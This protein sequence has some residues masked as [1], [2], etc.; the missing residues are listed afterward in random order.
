MRP[1]F[2]CVDRSTGEYIFGYP[3]YAEEG[4][5]FEVKDKKN[6][7]LNVSADIGTVAEYTGL[8][9]STGREIYEGDTVELNLFTRRALGTVRFV[10]GCWIVESEDVL[11]NGARHDY[12]KCYT[13]NHACKII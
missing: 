12:L 2:R 13:C 4:M 3:V 8:N 11:L 9:D 1:K 7:R 5:F 10:D 6:I